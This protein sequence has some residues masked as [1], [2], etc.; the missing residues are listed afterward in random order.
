MKKV[1][2]IIVA[3]AVLALAYVTVQ[4]VLAPVSFDKKQQEIELV[5]Q[6]QLKKIATYEDA[7]KS[8]YD[9]YA[10]KDELVNFLNNGRV[11]YIRAE[12]DYTSAMR[13]QGLSE[14]DAAR[15]GLIRR[16]TIWVSAKDS[17]LKDG[18]DLAK[19]FSI[20]GSDSTIQVVA[21]TIEQEVGDNKIQ[22]PVFQASAGYQ[23]YLGRL[24][25]DRLVKEKIEKANSKAN[26]FAGV[27]VGSLTE[28]KTNGNWE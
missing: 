15:R 22:V 20:P 19:L 18:T 10:D 13:E 25:N 14:E 1:I 3:V 17:L 12:G 6:K 11:F 26:A 23:S 24:G 4:S 27:R 7:Y 5:L 8:V 16:D 28:V 2:L 9:K 21:G